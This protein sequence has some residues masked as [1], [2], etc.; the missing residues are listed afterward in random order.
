MH[1]DDCDEKEYIKS[2]NL[3][4]NNSKQIYDPSSD[5]VGNSIKKANK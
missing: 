2:T 3:S 4:L 1:I 5:N